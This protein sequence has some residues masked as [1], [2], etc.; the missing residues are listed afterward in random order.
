MV[1][2]NSADWPMKER[3]R[4]G[5]LFSPSHLWLSLRTWQLAFEKAQVGL[6]SPPKALLAPVSLSFLIF[7]HIDLSTTAIT[8]LVVDISTSARQLSTLNDPILR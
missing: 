3:L 7:K 1:M 6:P 5:L 2:H 8:S 4:L